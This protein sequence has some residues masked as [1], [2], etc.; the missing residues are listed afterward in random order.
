MTVDH[1][2]LAWLI[3]QPA[4]QI[5]EQA[6]QMVPQQFLGDVLRRSRIDADD[7]CL[8]RQHLDGCGV[9]RAERAVAYHAGYQVDTLHT[10][11]RRKRTGEIDDIFCLPAGIRITTEFEL[12]P[13]DQTVDAQQEQVFA[14]VADS[15]P[16]TIV[17]APGTNLRRDAAH[18]VVG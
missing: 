8:A 17:S 1:V 14:R 4:H 11:L 15:H 9:V 6:V 10:L 18:A 3:L 5:V 2:G 16:P 7:A 12:M 13:P